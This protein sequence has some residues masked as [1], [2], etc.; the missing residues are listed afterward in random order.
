MTALVALLLCWSSGLLSAPDRI[1]LSFWP[2]PG[3]AKDARTVRIVDHPCGEVA[4]A[5]VATLP[6]NTKG[7]LVPEI[8]E[9]V[10]ARGGV[11]ASWPMPVDSY[12][13]A[14]RGAKLLLRASGLK[15]WV[16]RQG[17]VSRYAGQDSIPK[18]SDVSCL[19][20]PAGNA[21]I[22]CQALPDLGSGR[23]RVLRY[24]AP[25]T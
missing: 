5:R 21:Y 10:N 23:T 17:G 3:A 24:E 15:L 20:K 13:M 2:G 12:P 7:T 8:A 22:V 18:A 9:E 4:V 25:C 14:F 1:E 16:D 19:R 6:T 11:I